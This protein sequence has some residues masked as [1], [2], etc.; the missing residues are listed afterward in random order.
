[1]PHIYLVYIHDLNQPEIIEK[2]FFKHGDAK[3]YLP[4]NKMK[5]SL[6]RIEER[7]VE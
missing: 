7:E 1:M 4:R 3:K 6:Y 2:V 5:K